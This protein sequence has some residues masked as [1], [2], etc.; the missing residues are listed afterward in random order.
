MGSGRAMNKNRLLD[1]ITDAIETKDYDPQELTWDIPGYNRSIE[2]LCTV[3][4]FPVTLDRVPE[5]PKG[6]TR[7]GAC[8]HIGGR[9]IIDW[10]LP[11]AQ[12]VRTL[13]H[14]IAHAVLHPWPDGK[15]PEHWDDATRSREVQAE[16]AAFAVCRHYGLDTSLYSIP[17]IAG[18][19]RKLSVPELENDIGTALRTARD[20]IAAI[21]A[22]IL[23]RRPDGPS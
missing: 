2:I 16:A 19:A 12:T 4:P 21:D 11:G 18:W 22:E 17:Y 10:C 1:M 7:Y 15:K 3:S 8:D 6:G 5:S 14:E 9:I 23:K 13:L 20:L